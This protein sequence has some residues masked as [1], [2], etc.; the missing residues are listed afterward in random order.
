MGTAIVRTTTSSL[1]PAAQSA[2]LAAT[3]VAGAGVAIPTGCQNMQIVNLGP[4]KAY[5]SISPSAAALA[6]LPSAAP[7]FLPGCLPINVGDGS[8]IIDLTAIVSAVPI[9]ISA[10]CDAA[11]SAGLRVVCW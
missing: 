9:Y 1:R 5:V 3:P 8:T 11:E 6:V 7:A 10:I 4:N 2:S